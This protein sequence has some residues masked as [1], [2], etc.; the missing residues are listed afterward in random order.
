MFPGEVKR[1]GID[2]RCEFP[3]WTCNWHRRLAVA[4]VFTVICTSARAARWDLTPRLYIGESY[5]DNV[6]LVSRNQLDDFITEITPG[7]SVRGKGSRLMVNLDYNYQLRRYAFNPKF[8]ADSNQLQ[9]NATANIIRDILFVDVRGNISQQQISPRGGFSSSNLNVT[10]NRATV[11]TYGIS[12]YVRHHFGPY[13]QSEVRYDLDRIETTN[14]GQTLNTAAQQAANQLNSDRTN[15]TAYLQ[16]GRYFRRL[17]WKVDFS[18]SET[19]GRGTSGTNANFQRVTGSLSY[20]LTRKYRINSTVG[21]EENTYTS[22]QG[23]T[24]G[25]F[26]TLGGTWTPS[27]RTELTAAFGERYFGNTISM[28]ASHRHKHWIFTADYSEEPRLSTQQILSQQLIPLVDAFGQ[29]VFNPDTSSRIFLP[30]NTRQLTNQ[31]YIDKRLTAALTYQTPRNT[32]SVN[33]YTS[34]QTGQATGGAQTQRGL[35]MTWTHP[36]SP[37]LSGGTGANWY[38][39]DSGTGG[40]FTYY[41]FRPF[42]KYQLGPSINA[43]LEYR[44]VENDTDSV[45]GG[46]IEN[47]VSAFL[48]M[49]L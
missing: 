42:L 31:V 22:S 44:Y 25:Q 37:R 10:G 41:E 36:L 33:G 12:P 8:N 24:S 45:G 11:M 23:A 26:W 32:I 46:Y 14:G 2:G 48:S 40:Q 47:M 27:P 20:V 16:S 29:P 43:N 49:H 35:G 9:A 21:Y 3:H 13:A 1:P 39:T 34:D 28:H 18:R 5:S 17:P 6:T 19:T 7:V 30:V 38:T 15:L 4:L